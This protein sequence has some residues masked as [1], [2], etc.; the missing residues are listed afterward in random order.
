MCDAA[1]AQEQ[2]NEKNTKHVGS[3]GPARLGDTRQAVVW[4]SL[5]GSCPVR[6]P[7]R[8]GAESATTTPEIVATAVDANLPSKRAEGSSFFGR[9]V[10]N[11]Q[12]EVYNRSRRARCNRY[13]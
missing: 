7:P 8:Y 4:A 3:I 10:S 9:S 6:L 1:V 5:C 11:V 13:L 12:C 2:Q